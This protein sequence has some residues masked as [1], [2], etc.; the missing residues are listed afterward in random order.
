[1]EL[2][3]AENV[4]LETEEAKLGQQYQKLI[5]AQ[6]VVFRGEE[7]DAGADGR[8]LEEPDRALRRR[9]GIG[10]QAPFAG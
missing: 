9:R 4:A 8:F 5:G 10:R 2:F 3:R 6:T 1:V 7:K